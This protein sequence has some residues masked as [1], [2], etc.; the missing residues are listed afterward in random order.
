[1]K[2][3]VFYIHGKGGCAVESKHCKPH[4]P[5]LAAHGSNAL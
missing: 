4:L 5:W 1:M 2:K 3:L